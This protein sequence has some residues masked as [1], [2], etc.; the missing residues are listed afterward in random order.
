MAFMLNFYTMLKLIKTDKIRIHKIFFILNL[1][2]FS[3]QNDHV[4]RRY[5]KW[6]KNIFPSTRLHS[7]SLAILLSSSI[8]FLW[9][10]ALLSLIALS[11]FLICCLHETARRSS[12]SISSLEASSSF[13]SMVEEEDKTD[14]PDKTRI[15]KCLEIHGGALRLTITFYLKVTKNEIMLVY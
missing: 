14:K 7:S 3:Y 1:S 10:E 15:T 13:T 6:M 12:H 2:V 8:S 9:R 11:L 5:L 4:M